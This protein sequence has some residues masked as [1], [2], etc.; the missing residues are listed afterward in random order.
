MKRI[1]SFLAA[2]GFFAISSATVADISVFDKGIWPD[3]WPKELEALRGQSR[4]YEGPAS[5]DREYLIPFTKREDFEAAWPHLL[6]VKSKGAPIVLLRG[7]R[8]GFFAIAAGVIVN[9]PPL[10]ANP[11]AGTKW[12]NTTY[13]KLVVD[14]QI[15]DLNRIPLPEDTPIM[16]RRFEAKEG[17][18]KP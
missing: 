17:D 5:A 16:D 4:T 3:S 2:L 1:A 14:G 10:G 12:S 11:D 15:V 6:K 9:A 13:I 7:P 18:K 8:T